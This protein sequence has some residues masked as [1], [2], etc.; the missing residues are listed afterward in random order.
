MNKRL[1]Y[2][3][4]IIMCIGILPGCTDRLDLED[5]TNNLAIGLDLDPENNMIFY[6]KNPVYGMNI[7]KHTSEIEVKAKTVRDARAK[8]DEYT[9]GVITG[10]KVQIVL[11]GKRILEHEGWFQVMDVFFR[12]MKNP[13]TPRVI[14]VDGPISDIIYLNPKDQPMLPLMLRGMVDTKSERSETTKTTLQK[15]HWQIYEKGVTPFIP[16][17]KLDKAK[18]VKLK[19]VALLD[20]TGKYTVS[21]QAEDTILLQILNGNAKKPVNLTIPIP[22]EKKNSLFHTDHLSITVQ[23]M[24]TKVKTSYSQNKF[25]FDIHIHIPASLTER[26]FPFDVRKHGKELE[27]KISEQ[28]QKKFASLIKTI[29]EHQIDPIG[30]G[31]YA[32][33]HEYQAYKKVEDQWG[34]ALSK[35]DIQLSVQVTIRS[36]GPMK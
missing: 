9:P 27:K 25:K 35:A 32:R 16:E 3:M 34:E 22:G 6:M 8:L 29:Q 18:K 21:L 30:L 20:H 23:G 24:K 28:L 31:L 10:R 19:G 13:L 11:I 4:Y 2:V 14:A 12:D 17:I 7:K 15:L 26:L 33:A 1:P 5:S 36:M